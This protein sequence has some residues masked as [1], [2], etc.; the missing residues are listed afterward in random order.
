MLDAQCLRLLNYSPV[1]AV[2]CGGATADRAIV[3]CNT[4]FEDLTGFSRA[5]LMG[6]DLQHLR[7]GSLESTNSDPLGQALATGQDISLIAAVQKKSGE[8][9]DSLFHVSHLHTDAGDL[10]GILACVF[11]LSEPNDMSLARGYGSLVVELKQ[12]VAR[13]PQQTVA[14]EQNP[15]WPLRQIG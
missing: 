6:R 8:A 15:E 14:P 10:V 5:D 11:D 1:A 2:I 13:Q 7:G 4:A 9:L 3:Y 12:Q